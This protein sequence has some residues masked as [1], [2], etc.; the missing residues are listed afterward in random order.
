M[1][2]VVKFN[3]R[4][5]TPAEFKELLERSGL[6]LTEFLYLSGR[7][8]DVIEQW[9]NGNHNGGF[10]PTMADAMILELAAFN[11]DLVD[12]MLDIADRYELD[13]NRPPIEEEA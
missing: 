4:R 12:D 1:P 6:T 13:G 3:H 7:R 10:V 2:R 5:L 11:E 8:S 9:S